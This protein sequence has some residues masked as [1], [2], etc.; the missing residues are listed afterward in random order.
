MV[1]EHPVISGVS[2]HCTPSFM[3]LKH[4]C[5]KN[6]DAGNWTNTMQ[7]H[8]REKGRSTED[9]NRAQVSCIREFADSDQRKS[10]S[11]ARK[12]CGSTRIK[13]HGVSEIELGLYDHISSN[14]NGQ[15]GKYL[16]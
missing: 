15:E 2:P 14:K 4:A 1:V 6:A 7:V 9:I 12:I 5:T 10:R 13:Y 8:F 16:T 11:E 3:T